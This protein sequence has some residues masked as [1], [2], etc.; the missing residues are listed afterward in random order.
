MRD[1]FLDN[2]SWIGGF[3]AVIDNHV[4][5]SWVGVEASGD[6]VPGF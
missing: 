4:R 6:S 2:S 3:I 1:K 5:E